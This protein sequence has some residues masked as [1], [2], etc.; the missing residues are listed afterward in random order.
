MAKQENNPNAL[1]NQRELN[2]AGS[3]YL[4]IQKE[5]L[6]T[7]KQMAGFQNASAA[8]QR[9]IEQ[10]MSAG[11]KLA[12]MLEGYTKE[13]LKSARKRQAFQSKFNE[14][15]SK[16][17]GIQEDINELMKDSTKESKKLAKTL[18][19]SEKFS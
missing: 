8:E 2:Q 11:N 19:S 13:D 9:K 10:T 4:G 14:F 12:K 17:A 7:M 16:E 6:S 1:K 15:K 18:K 3:E 5:I